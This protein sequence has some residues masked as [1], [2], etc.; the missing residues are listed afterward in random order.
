[1]PLVLF[2]LKLKQIYK[3]EQWPIAER[4]RLGGSHPSSTP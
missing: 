1:M 2:V 3:A 4:M